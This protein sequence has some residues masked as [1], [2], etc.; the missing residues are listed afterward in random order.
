MKQ[1]KSQK[2]SHINHLLKKNT[3]T[4]KTNNI[5][6]KEFKNIIFKIKDIVLRIT[7]SSPLVLIFII[8]SLLNEILLRKLTVNNP[9]YYKPFFIDIGIIFIF[10]SIAFL[11]KR[12]N[13]A[14][15][16]IF[17][18]FITAIICIINCNYYS[19]Y[20]SFASVSLL[21][22]STQL[23]GVNDAVLEVI[24]PE[25]FIFIW[26]P[27]FLIYIHTKFKKKGIYPKAND[28]NNKKIY[29]PSFMGIGV[30][31]LCIISLFG[32]ENPLYQHLELM[33]TKLMI[34]FKAYNLK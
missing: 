34:L 24:K 21:A 33:S 11:L 25:Y 7:K 3:P 6:I 9:F 28:K 19:Y 12:K 32:I 15:Y 5:A 17:L 30:L 27:I 23:G 1:S 14:K 10:S 16:L 22:T 31:T 13:G 20:S 2:K 29:F 18:S 8:T 4:D 26:Q